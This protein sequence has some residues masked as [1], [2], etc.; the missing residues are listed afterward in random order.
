[1]KT[2]IS[3]GFDAGPLYLAVAFQVSETN[4]M[5]SFP[6]ATSATGTKQLFSAIFNKPHAISLNLEVVHWTLAMPSTAN[7]LVGQN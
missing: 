2:D 1:M 7:S 4:E 3:S 6:L 5:F